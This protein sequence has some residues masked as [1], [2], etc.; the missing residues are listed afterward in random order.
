MFVYYTLQSYNLYRYNY[1]FCD[2]FLLKSYVLSIVTEHLTASG[3]CSRYERF[4][5][6]DDISVYCCYC[7][8]IV[9]LISELVYILYV[10][11]RV[12]IN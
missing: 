2:C 4:F 6:Y 3:N 12:S 1:S 5:L 10:R 11:F 8:L 7:V 9:T